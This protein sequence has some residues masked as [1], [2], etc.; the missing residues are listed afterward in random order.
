MFTHI[1]GMATLTMK[2][3]NTPFHQNPPSTLGWGS[4]MALMLRYTKIAVGGV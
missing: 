2:R 4:S 1:E 3:R